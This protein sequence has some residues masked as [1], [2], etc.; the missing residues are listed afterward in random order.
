MG[1]ALRRSELKHLGTLLNVGAVGALT[2]DQ[3]IERFLNRRGEAS[4]LAFAVLVERHGPMVLRVCRAVLRNAHDAQDA[5]QGTFLVLARRAGSIR[6][7][8]SLGS[9][10]HGAAYR[11]ASAARSATNRRRRH[12]ERRGSGTGEACEDAERFE[13]A[14]VLHDEINSLPERF[15][16]PI[17]LCYLEGLTHEQTAARLACPVGTVRSRL[18][19]GRDQLRA[20]LTRR[21]V[22]PSVAL[23]AMAVAR[24]TSYNPVP[25]SLVSA[26]ARSA[27]ELV[28]ART[29]AAPL[30]SLLNGVLWMFSTR[31]KVA[32][33]L[34]FIAALG[35]AQ[36]TRGTTDGP[37]PT[38]QQPRANSKVLPQAGAPVL[39][40]QAQL[41]YDPDATVKLRPRFEAIITKV[42]VDIGDRVKKGDP[43]GELMSKE[44]AQA[45]REFLKKYL[46]S[47]RD[48]KA[49]E[50]AERLRA[51]NL[52]PEHTKAAD[53]TAQSRKVRELS[54]AMDAIKLVD[55][56]NKAEKSRLGCALARDKLKLYSVSDD[57][58]VN[59]RAGLD[60]MLK[61]GKPDDTA[62]LALSSP[63]DGLVIERGVNP[64]EHV[65]P[66]SV[67]MIV[68][69]TDHLWVWAAVPDQYHSRI[70]VG[71]TVTVIVP[72]REQP[73]EGKVQ[74]LERDDSKE[75]QTVKVRAV[76]PNP[77]ADLFGGMPVRMRIAID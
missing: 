21:G 52:E 34:L 47:E 22:A 30:A 12:E 32:A 58:I 67:M 4:E 37:T 20:R 24:E 31:L 25:A 10:L 26:T 59:L 15:R 29:L 40:L 1:N 14:P 53:T 54:D 38:P 61:N 63:I 65:Q 36:A 33:V 66:S 8:N 16:A 68:C 18:S 46:E 75:P 73:V 7:R 49:V 27:F 62:K 77:K 51:K 60:E 50:R 44:L 5:F 57:E 70:R 48:K 3:L 74:L 42:N 23:A 2:D 17:V 39:E 28:S 72:G 6:S 11:V 55:A 64:G 69:P 71:Q 41:A 9:W 19:R 13:L 45:E 56:R 43:L 76:I 35:V